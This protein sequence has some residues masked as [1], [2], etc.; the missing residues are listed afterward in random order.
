MATSIWVR[1]PADF[2]ACCRWLPT[3]APTSIAV[4]SRR[5]ARTRCVGCRDP[6]DEFCPDKV[7]SHFIL[8]SPLS[9]TFSVPPRARG[10]LLTRMHHPDHHA[11]RVRGRV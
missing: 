1:K 9:T 6:C 11:F 3:T 7:Y 10:R 5:T 8:L 4:S 2:P